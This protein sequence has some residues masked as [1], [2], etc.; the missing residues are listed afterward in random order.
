MSIGPRLGFVGRQMTESRPGA[1]PDRPGVGASADTPVNRARDRRLGRLAWLTG[2]LVV[3]VAVAGWWATARD[4]DAPAVRTVPDTRSAGSGTVP[5]AG[6]SPAAPLRVAV[7]APQ[8]VV[9]GEP[10]DFAITWSDGE[11]IFSGTSEDWGDGVGASSLAQQACDL[12]PPAGPAGGE[13]TVR[14]TFT[15]PGPYTVVLGVSTYTCSGAEAVTETATQT[16]QVDVLPEATGA[17]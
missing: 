12:A 3:V 2:C 8:R 14:H 7:T 16:V 17:G 11:G 10:A 4:S 1:S 5:G 15:V 9:A 6:P 13:V